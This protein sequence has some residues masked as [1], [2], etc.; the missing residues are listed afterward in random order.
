LG[1]S[2]LPGFKVAA[3]VELDRIAPLS[4]SAFVKSWGTAALARQP[5]VTLQVLAPAELTFAVTPLIPQR[6]VR[7]ELLL[8]VG[9]HAF[10]WALY[11]EV[12]TSG[13]PA[14]QHDVTLAPHFR[15]DDVSVTEDEAERLV[16]WTQAEQRL[17]LFLRDSTTGIQNLVLE[18]RDAVPADG[19][20][21][22]PTHW[23]ADAE[24]TEFSLRVTH[25]PS[26]HVE[27]LDDQQ[28][29]L[30]AAD[31][32]GAIPDQ[33]E[34]VLGKFRADPK[35]VLLDVRLTPHQPAGRAAAWSQVTLNPGDAWSWRHVE[36]L[37]DEGQITARIFWPTTWASSGSMT[38]SP[39]LKELARRP[40]PDGIELTVQSLPDI[41]GP[42]DV[43]FESQP[44]APTTDPMTSRNPNPIRL[45]PPTSLDVAERTHHWLIAED[46]QTWLPTS[47]LSG[48]HP[49]DDAKTLPDRLPHA[50]ATAAKWLL[51]PNTSELELTQ[52]EPAGAPPFPKLLW[53]DTTVWVTDGAITQGRTW[54]LLQPYGLREFVLDRPDE[55]HW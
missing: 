21:P 52:P 36:R 10:E 25:D 23:F 11:A 33:S 41:R 7:Q 6:K 30:G 12:S 16:S 27:V 4:E 3:P 28:V 49:L 45:T 53:M 26:W 13:S 9:R 5:Q 38:L 35:S 42:R 51:T 1:V 43:L 46:L 20:L 22:I 14:F 47:L 50:P 48:L 19:R 34:L 2:S 32:G 39:T 40:L 55:V 18:G 29:P 24:S 31:A 44:A 15:A 8:K 37:L 54:L 17:S